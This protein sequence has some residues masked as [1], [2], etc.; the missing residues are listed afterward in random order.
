MMD[1]DADL[2]KL[3]HRVERLEAHFQRFVDQLQNEIGRI[4][5]R[6]GCNTQTGEAISDVLDELLVAV[7]SAYERTKEQ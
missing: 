1:K 7:G 2:I 4:A 3:R 5:S 6:Y